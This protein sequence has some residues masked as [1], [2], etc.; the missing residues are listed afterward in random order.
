MGQTTFVKPGKVQGKDIRKQ[1]RSSRID[2]PFVLI[3]I[4]LVAI[5]LLAVYSTSWVQSKILYGSPHTFALRQIL[6]TIIGS[7]IATFLAFY[8][9]HKLEH[10]SLIIMGITI[11]LLII[12]LLPIAGSLGR[13]LIRNSV[14]PSEL[15]KAVIVIYLAV[16]LNARQDVINSFTLGFIP[17]ISI[18]GIVG[19]LILIQPDAS[20][21]LTVFILGGLLFFFAGGNLRQ[22][23]LLIIFASI[24]GYLVVLISGKI[25]RIT[26]FIGSMG[27]VSAAPEQIQRAIQAISRGGLFGVGIGNS[28]TKN[29]GLQVAWTDSIFAV[30]TE[31]TGLL[32]AAT[33]IGLYLLLLWR[34]LD[35]ANRA[36]DLL[37]KLLASGMT[38]WI[39]IEAMINISV[40][41]SLIPV[42]GNALPFISMGGSSMVTSLAAVGIILNISRAAKKETK[43]T[44]PVERTS[45]ANSD[46]RRRNGRRSVSGNVH[47]AS[48]RAR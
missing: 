7:I 10:W 29:T 12:V 15:A 19:G 18:V 17:M 30:I 34:G 36:P 32:G 40:M 3:V 33:V 37:G 45:S 13:N 4:C 27:N 42:A 5:G 8:D 14:Q 25:E 43:K 28:I 38:I 46:L 26:L 44:A 48:T 2:L 47:S 1:L 16:W 39:A 9:Y 23:F 11:T 21:V 22:I 35:I 20:A 41:L 24:V 31:E 6:W